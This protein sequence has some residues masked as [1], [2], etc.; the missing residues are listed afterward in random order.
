MET[1]PLL[2]ARVK[3][4]AE[5]VWEVVSAATLSKLLDLPEFKVTHIEDEGEVLHLKCE[6]R[7]MVAM[8]PRCRELSAKLHQCGDRAVRDL[9]IMGK[10]VILHFPN[11]RFRCENCRRPF[12]ERLLSIDSRRR[13]TRRYERYIYEQCLDSDRKAV[14]EREHLSQSTVKEIFVK[15]A[16]RVTRHTLERPVRVLGIDEISLKKRHKQYAL[17]LSDLEKRCVIAILPDRKKETLIRWLKALPEAERRA[18]RVVST[19]LW[20]PYRQAVR[21]VLPWAQ[22]VADRF[23]VMKQINNR[24]TQARRA[25]QKQANE[26]TREILK[27]SRWVLVKARDELT[28][29]EEAK[30]QAVLNASPELRTMYLLKEEFRT[31]CNKAQ[32]REQAARFLRAWICKVKFTGDTRLLKFVNTLLN[33]WDEFL[34]YFIDHITQAFVEGINNAIRTIIR[35]AYG[36]RNFDHFRLQVLAQHGSS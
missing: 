29:K 17:V 5:R 21:E 20:E 7:E 15:W 9:S 22:Q 16:K 14:A 3:Q 6:H 23:H 10:R 2:S 28:P 30:L 24:L 26:A 25:L 27:G 32:N 4:T 33:W 35:R 31:I 19:D 18:I 13:Q 36:F 1:I 12:T 8:C 34:N 11:R